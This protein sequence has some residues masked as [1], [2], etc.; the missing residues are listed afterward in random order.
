MRPACTS[1]FPLRMAASLVLGL[2]MGS[3]SG[4]Q[5]N[6]KRSEIVATSRALLRFGRGASFQKADKF[7]EVGRAHIRYGPELEAAAVSP[8]ARPDSLILAC[9]SQWEWPRKRGR[10]T[11]NVGLQVV[12]VWDAPKLE[13]DLDNSN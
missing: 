1:F 8:A 6:L 13:L 7:R 4:S 2:F 11:A 3:I 5:V 9:Y 12:H 10:S